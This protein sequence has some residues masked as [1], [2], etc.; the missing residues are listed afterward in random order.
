MSTPIQSGTGRPIAPLNTGVEGAQTLTPAQQVGSAAAEMNA[1]QALLDA[2]KKLG[3]TPGDAASRLAA[4]K[5]EVNA[6][7]AKSI[8]NSLSLSMDG[9]SDIYAAMALFQKFAQEVRNSNREIR[10]S[11]LQASVQSL[12]DAAQQMK[13]AAALRLAAGIV[14]GVSQVVA[15]AT[16]VVGGAMSMIQ[17]GRAAAKS[18]E[19]S[20]LANEGKFGIDAKGDKISVE[21][22][23][24]SQ[25]KA[26][27]LGSQ[28]SAL[29]RS[30]TMWSEGAGGAAKMI[31][32]V[33]QIAQSV[34][35]H[36]AAL[37]DAK[38]AELEAQSKKHDAA[39]QA[40]NEMMQQ[41]MD[42]IRDIRE[43]LQSIDQARIETNK[44]ISKNV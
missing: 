32:G 43:K 10:T 6:E 22:Q 20:P 21:Q 4:P 27:T 31:G 5:T 38:K 11:E 29:N 26:D 34:L 30:A 17:G 2:G 15:G 25:A 23:A 16:Q 18:N 24:S 44:T 35:E 37:K 33:G 40:A 1:A 8:G 19:A 42:V 12:M 13:E 9:P 3:F 39:M 41:M 28:A 14:S 36:Q 7:S